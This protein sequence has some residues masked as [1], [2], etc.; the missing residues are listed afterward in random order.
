M[1]FPLSQLLGLSV[2]VP[3]Q[4]PLHCDGA[5]TKNLGMG[6]EFAFNDAADVFNPHDLVGLARPGNG[7][8][9]G[10]GDLVLVPVSKWSFEEKKF[11]LHW[12][13]NAQTNL[14]VLM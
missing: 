11:V 1:W 5:G 12:P 3:I 7:V 9:N 14:K 2:Q 13:S 6:T 10:L 4:H 8:A